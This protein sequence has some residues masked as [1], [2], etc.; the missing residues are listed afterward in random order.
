MVG[1]APLGGATSEDLFHKMKKNR[2]WVEKGMGRGKAI[3]VR[4]GC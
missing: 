2:E 3:R 1:S 4:V